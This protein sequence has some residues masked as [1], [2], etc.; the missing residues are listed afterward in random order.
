M[1]GRGFRGGADKKIRRMWLGREIVV[2][3]LPP[4]VNIL[5]M[6]YHNI[7]HKT[8][9]NECVKSGCLT[10]RVDCTVI[11]LIWKYERADTRGVHAP[12]LGTE[13]EGSEGGLLYLQIYFYPS[14]V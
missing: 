5:F 13:L 4:L 10:R 9:H 2:V 3:G 8:I 1:K 11:S 7:N 6:K 12:N 14:H